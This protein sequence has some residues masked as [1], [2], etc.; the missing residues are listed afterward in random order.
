MAIF[1][2]ACPD[3]DRGG[4]LCA[5]VAVAVCWTGA[6]LGMVGSWVE[7]SPG[8]ACLMTCVL[9]S[10]ASALTIAPWQLPARARATVEVWRPPR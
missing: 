4:Y 6:L 2:I 1:V 8:L 10:L 9:L 3:P 7:A 5:P